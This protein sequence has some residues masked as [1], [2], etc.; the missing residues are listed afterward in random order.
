MFKKSLKKSLEDLMDRGILERG[1]MILEDEFRPIKNLFE[2]RKV[3][4]KGWN[5]HQVELLFKL[6]SMMDTDKDAK[7]ARVGEREGR[8]SSGYVLS[9]A[10]GFSHGIGR[11]GDIG[12][13]Q[14]KAA[15]GSI[16]NKLSSYLATYFLKRVGLPAVKSSIV[17]PVATGMSIA[18]CLSMIH[19]E[20]EKDGDKNPWK[21][22]EVIIP[23]VD[24]KS[25]VKGIKF[26]GFKP[27]IVE[28]ELE[29]DSV[30]VRPEQVKEHVTE[31]TGAIV[32][33]TAFFPPR[34]PD[35]VKDI[36]K[37]CRD[38][39]IAHVINNS[40]GVQSEV[41]M[42]IVRGAMDAGRVDFIVQ[43][44]DKNFLTPVGGAVVASA[45]PEKIRALS[46]VYAGR[47]SIQPLLQFI[48]STL[49]LGIEGYKN[50]MHEQV[51]NRKFLEKNVKEFSGEIGQRLLNVNNPI[52]VAMTVSGFPKKIGGILYNLRVTGPRVIFPGD[53]G[54]CINNYPVP[55]MTLNAGIGAR[56]QDFENLIEKLKVLFSQI[57]P[58]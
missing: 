25:P 30:V 16:V 15:G 11:S 27:V 17:L 49:T 28:G 5:D 34:H 45:S 19:Q 1:L 40:Y 35:F 56:K 43:S 47:A 39:G 38:L 29:G 21:K 7:A 54:S 44:T 48:A 6:L 2:Q 3:P 9:L 18:L 52:A 46:R 8:T 33:T 4:D 23:R 13:I 42:K 10:E 55:Y 22:N 12:A 31:H 24:H 32:S 57:S 50:L 41:F 53:Y 26:A 20:L 14:P 36:S 58:S 37:L 51:Q